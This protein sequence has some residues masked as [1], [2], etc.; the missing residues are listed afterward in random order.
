MVQSQSVTFNVLI[1]GPVVETIKPLVFDSVSPI[2][3]TVGQT[4][5]K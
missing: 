5:I 3:S 1:I 2:N 4:I